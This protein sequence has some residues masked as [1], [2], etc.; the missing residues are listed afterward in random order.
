MIFF[1]ITIDYYR[2]RASRVLI[3]GL[4]GLGSEVAK[5]I[6]LAG[7]KSIHFMDDQTVYIMF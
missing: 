3:I 1:Y 6:I 2:L 7:V 4:G 5:N